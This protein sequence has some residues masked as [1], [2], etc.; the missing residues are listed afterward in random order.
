M[1]FILHRDILRPDL[2]LGKLSLGG[3]FIC[4]SVEDAVRDVKIAGNTCIPAGT[5][6]VIINMSNR[7]KRLMPL[8][9][10]VPQ[11]QGVRIHAGNSAADTEGCI[12]LGAFRTDTGVAKS[13]DAVIHVQEMIR[14]A[15]DRGEEVTIEIV[16]D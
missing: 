3:L 4:Y 1:K 13:K 7:F 8:L 15:L 14:A 6:K 9:L 5:Y 11:F 12:I 2:T 10:D 16:E